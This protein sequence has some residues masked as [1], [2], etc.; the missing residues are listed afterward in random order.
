MAASSAAG[1][2]AGGAGTSGAASC[3]AVSAWAIQ[4]SS[5]S[6]GAP[7]RSAEVCQTK[8]SSRPVAGEIGARLREELDYVLE[9]KHIDLYRDMLSNE[10]GVHVPEPVPETATKSL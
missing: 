7:S 8:A 4:E 2:G 9:R 10:A 3:G 5:A 6:I 1:G